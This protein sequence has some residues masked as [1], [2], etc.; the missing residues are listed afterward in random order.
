MKRIRSSKKWQ[1]YSYNKPRKVQRAYYSNQEKKQK[2]YIIKIIYLIFIFLLIQAIFHL[3]I[4]KIKK[5]SL[6]NNKD[7]ILTEI[8]EI[9]NPFLNTKRFFIFKNSNYFLLN[10]N[11]LINYLSTEYNLEN[12]EIKKVFPNKLNII[13]QERI[14]S[15]IWQKDDALYLLTSQGA[16]NRKISDISD[17]HDNYPILVDLRAE[18]ANKEQIFTDLELNYIN[19]IYILWNEVIG[20]KIMIK[21]MYIEDSKEFK[22]EI[23]LGY[24][25]IFNKEKDIKEQLNNL[26][27]VLAEDIIGAEIEYIDLSFGDK[28]YFK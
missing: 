15:F 25:I 2:K 14:S 20:D 12:I 4:F 11:Y 18:E 21:K 5:I 24:N 1:K 28:V 17:K 13:V 19:T 9:I 6:E 26:N 7:I 22:I 23:N 27:K 16:L 10:K 3:P 8:E